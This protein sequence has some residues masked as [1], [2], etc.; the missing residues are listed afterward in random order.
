MAVFRVEKMKYYTHYTTL[1]N[2]DT[3]NSTVANEN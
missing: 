1:V 3:A 2:H